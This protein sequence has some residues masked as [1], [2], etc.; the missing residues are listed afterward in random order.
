MSTPV[1][2]VILM[3]MHAVLSLLTVGVGH[4]CSPTGGCSATFAD[5]HRCRANRDAHPV[6][7]VLRLAGE[8]WYTQFRNTWY[9][10]GMS[11]YDAEL[12]TYI[13]QTE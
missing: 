1:M 13:F 10:H 4:I 11:H 5:L 12:W 3:K 2:G 9:D 6:T 7:E 8:D